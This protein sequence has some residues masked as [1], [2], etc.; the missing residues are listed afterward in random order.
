MNLKAIEIQI[1]FE[2]A[3][4]IG[5][6]LEL[7]QNLKTALS[8]YLRKLGCSTGMVLQLHKKNQNVHCSSCFTIPRNSFKNPVYSSLFNQIPQKFSHNELETF[9]ATLPL[10]G[11]CGDHFHFSVSSLPG[12]GFLLLIKSE[13]PFSPNTLHSLRQLN[14]KLADSCIS[15][16]QKEQIDT[17]NLQLSHE[18]E[19]RKIS[20]KKLQDL[21]SNLEGEIADR[22]KALEESKHRY[23]AIFD[24][25]QDIYFSLDLKG[26]I[27]EISPSVE[28]TLLFPREKLIGR[29]IAFFG[30]SKEDTANFMQQLH[31]KGR[32][33]EYN[34]QIH[35]RDG[36]LH[37]FSLNAI[38]TE[39]SGELPL[40]IIGSMRDITRQRNAE[41]SKEKLESQ[42]LNSRKMEALGLLAGGVA[43]DLNNVLSGIVSYPDLLLAQLDDDNPLTQPIKLIRDSGNKAAAIV[44]DLLTMARRNVP[45]KDVFNINTIIKAYLASPEFTKLIE[46]H[47]KLVVI[48]DLS[49]DL[50]NIKGSAL[51]IKTALMNLIHNGAEAEATTVTITTSNAYLEGES[52]K[53]H[54]VHEGDYTL[55]TI[56]DNGSGL[57]SE[58]RQRIFEPFYTKKV[59]GKSGTGLGMSVV[60]G[61]IQDHNGYVTISSGKDTGTSFS[62]YIPGTR[63][64]LEEKTPEVPTADYLAHGES[65]LV[66]DDSEDQ[67]HIAKAMLEALN[68]TVYSVASGEAAVELTPE[69]HPDLILLDMIMEHGM[70]GLD[71]YRKVR[72][73]NP[74][75]KVIIVSGYSETGRVHEALRLGAHA[76]IKKPYLLGTFG[77]VLRE[78]LD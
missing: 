34:L 39:S 13:H 53:H 50:L 43:H 59:M 52:A 42:L 28:E 36:V 41:E 22:T 55:I 16:L 40:Q 5:T 2:I 21:L 29:S 78:C 27:I 51:H 68:Y 56:T 14:K 73:H 49:S 64:Q 4:A 46:T 38:Q 8:A 7:K 63:Q 60:W 30:F 11:M 54:K 33:K 69:I 25:I 19:L 37:H 10:Q 6:S 26:R 76:Y 48:T 67:R 1:Y 24:N 74:D 3:M 58:D 12:F 17:I 65:I 75:Q 62:L 57:T 70:D 9:I 45:Q 77:K 71:T 32:V 44:Q 35:A 61:T 47:P 18:I 72:Q 66:V 15:C 31:S 23:K 20:D